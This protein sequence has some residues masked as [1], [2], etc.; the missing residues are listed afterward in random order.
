M[1]RIRALALLFPLF[2]LS[3]TPHIVLA[4]PKAP[5]SVLTPGVYRG[6]I[7]MA[8][9]ISYGE[10]PREGVLHSEFDLVLQETTGV[11]QAA[12]SPS[13]RIDVAFGLM[14]WITYSDWEEVKD[15]GSG[16]CL[17]QKSEASGMA[18]ISARPTPAPL[19]PP[20]PTFTAKTTF[21]MLSFISNIEY[22]GRECSNDVTP[23]DMLDILDGGFQ[24][25]F[26]SPMVFEIYQSTPAKISGACSLPDFELDADHTFVCTW[27]VILLERV[28]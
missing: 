2:V 22:F 14:P 12:V 1:L 21:E 20:Q 8:G 26:L 25:M 9:R 3:Q 28:K 16:G 18:F 4:A 27:Y 15:I 23:E 6:W 24:D 19:A 10:P 11:M 17:G 13:G 7:N 5:L